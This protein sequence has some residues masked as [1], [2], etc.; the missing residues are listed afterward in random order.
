MSSKHVSA[1]LAC[2]KFKGHTLVML[3]VLC[4]KAGSGKPLPNGHTIPEG[5]VREVTDKVLMKALRTKRRTTVFNCRKELVKA[6][7]ITSTLIGNTY[8]GRNTYPIH[9]YHIN[10]EGLLELA[11]KPKHSRGRAKAKPEQSQGI[12]SREYREAIRTDQ[13]KSVHTD[14]PVR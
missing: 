14:P 2:G 11:P 12:E 7:I 10:L 5:D 3:L 8:K 9:H 1:A 6:G 13:R 4:H